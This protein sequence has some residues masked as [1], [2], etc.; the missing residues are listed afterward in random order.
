MASL[1]SVLANPAVR[2]GGSVL[3]VRSSVSVLPRLEVDIN[4]YYI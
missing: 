3:G 2:S 4:W 1:L